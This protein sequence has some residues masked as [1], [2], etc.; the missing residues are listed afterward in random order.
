M[1]RPKL[2]ALWRYRP[3]ALT[4]A[5]LLVI[6]TLIA[7][8]NLVSEVGPYLGAERGTAGWPL[9][10]HWHHFLV[11]PRP[12][13]AVTWEYDGKRLAG[14]I[15]IWLVVAAAPAAACEW[16]LRRYR[17]RLRWSLRTMLAGVTLAG[18][19]CGWFVM[20]R[21]RAE[22]QDPLIAT[23][24]GRF[25]PQIL[26]G[27]GTLMD[28]RARVW[29]RRR[30]P[31]W[32]HLVGAER[33]FRQIVGADIGESP[34]DESAEQLL[35][36]LAHVRQL[37][38]LF[39]NAYRLT[40]RMVD[41]LREMPRLEMLSIQFEEPAPGTAELLAEVL[42]G[43]P[44]LRVLSVICCGTDADDDSEM[45][46][47]CLAVIGKTAQLE[48][49]R[50]AYMPIDS[51]SLESLAGLTNLKS[52]SL[53]AISANEIERE[54]EPRLLSRLPALVALEALDLGNSQVDDRD[55]GRL[56]KFP[57]LKS[58]SLT[59]TKVTGAR[60][61]QLASL[62]SLEELAINGDA[63]SAA[64]FESLLA[65]KRL[66]RLHLGWS[67]RRN[68]AWLAIG[69]NAGSVSVPEQEHERCVRAIEALRRTKHGI[70]IDTN[71]WALQWPGP[72]M[73]PVE[74]ERIPGDKR[75]WAL[76]YLRDWNK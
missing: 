48:K 10:W 7:L 53:V 1:R 59:G 24:R 4:L 35:A 31:K 62:P 25:S 51:D 22:L 63:V 8:A 42:A 43:K 14:N 18:A 60:L 69:D 76:E 72:Y 11:Y 29:V 28:E 58:L 47:D 49:L 70:V 68:S 23:V 66:A 2:A 52:L 74:F 37:R 17:P 19:C 45:S 54:P 75:V 34:D 21:N 6:A 12:N 9:D 41:A 39:F 46:R 50:F 16:L 30:G 56:S 55:L 5:L 27:G 26:Y 73:L 71:D 36:R 32:F 38:Y 57:R 20:A 40:P 33:Y 65:V 13:G 67:Y 15:A 61:A 44:D 64:A 3:R